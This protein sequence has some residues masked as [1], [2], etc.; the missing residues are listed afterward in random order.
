M[1]NQ[2]SAATIKSSPCLQKEHGD[3]KA[4]THT[5]KYEQGKNRQK[6]YTQ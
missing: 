2:P 3:T 1:K 6:K 4:S 5:K